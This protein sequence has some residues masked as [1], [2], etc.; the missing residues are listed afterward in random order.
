MIRLNL[1]AEPAELETERA[2][3]L[4]LA[5]TAFNSHGPGAKQLTNLLDQGY[6]VARPTLRDRQHGKCA[7]CEKQEDAFKRPVEHFRPKKGAQDKQGGSWITVKTHYWW[8]TWTW[9]NLYFACDRCNMSGNKGSRFP[10][11]ASTNRIAAP[12]QPSPNPVAPVHYDCTPEQALLVDPRRDNPF[13]HLQWTPVNRN[14]PWRLWQWTIEGR[15]AKGDMT[16]E[17]LA[18]TERVDEVNLHI[19]GIM[20]LWEQIDSHITAGRLAN[21]MAAWD[22]MITNFVDNPRQPYR[23][24]A[25]WALLYLCPP[26]ERIRHGLRDPTLPEVR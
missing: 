11:Q 16:I 26:A 23:N 9:E 25:W 3:R 17:V 15:D 6:Q 14:E 1:G 13:D 2:T 20:L 10:I 18:L 22:S 24:A 21:A 5:I 4:P 7:F 12:S 19:K 8:L